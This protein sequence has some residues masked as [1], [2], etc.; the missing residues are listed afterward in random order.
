[1]NDRESREG[2]FR[3]IHNPGYDFL[4][5]SRWMESA[6]PENP[7]LPFAPYMIPVIG[8]LAACCAIEGYVNMV[9]QKID[10]NWNEFDKGPVPIKKCIQR[11]YEIVDK[12]ADFGQGVW[13]QVS[14][15][16]KARIQLVHPRY[17]HKVEIGTSEISTIFDE[18]GNQFQPSISLSIAS[19]AIDL[20]LSDTGLEKQKD[21]LNW[22]QRRYHG[23]ARY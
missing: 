20:L 4:R 7:D 18:V 23:P 22:T 12:Q 5:L 21:N 2:L 1:M 17:T 19:D 13:Q 16:F 6:D 15:L 8:V 10:T 14:Q 11:I 9:G 3:L